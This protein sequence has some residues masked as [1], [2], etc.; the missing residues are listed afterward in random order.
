M[1]TIAS[2]A[3][4]EGAVIVGKVE[5]MAD[6]NSGYDAAAD[7][8]TDMVKAGIIDPLKVRACAC[9]ACV[10]VCFVCVCVC[11]KGGCG[12]GVVGVFVCGCAGCVLCGGRRGSVWGRG[13]CFEERAESVSI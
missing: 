5:E 11:V 3:G 13:L 10:W 2:N 1:K 9:S 7:V 12:R 4:V 8:F 6:F